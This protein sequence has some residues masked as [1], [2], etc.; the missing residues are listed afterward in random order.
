MHWLVRR[1]ACH[2]HL[3]VHQA[4]CLLHHVRR[5]SLVMRLF[6]GSDALCHHH[7]PKRTPLSQ[8]LSISTSRKKLQTSINLFSV[9][10][11]PVLFAISDVSLPASL[12]SFQQQHHHPWPLDVCRARNDSRSRAD[13][14]VDSRSTTIPG[15]RPLNNQRYDFPEPEPPC[16]T[17][18]YSCAE[19][20]AT[21]NV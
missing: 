10:I 8:V 20:R 21:R 7:T 11:L 17:T 1:K 13:C 18:L 16:S 19:P 4:F 12:Q 6:N 14:P 5:R 3:L 15:N 9:A 2:Y